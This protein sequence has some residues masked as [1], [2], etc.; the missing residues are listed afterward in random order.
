MRVALGLANATDRWRTAVRAEEL[1]FD[2]AWF[3]DRQMVAAISGR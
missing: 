1:G 2:T 3:E